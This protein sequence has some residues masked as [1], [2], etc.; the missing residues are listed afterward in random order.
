MLQDAVRCLAVPGERAAELGTG[1]GLVAVS[2]A[3]AYRVVIATDLVKTLVGGVALT[4]ALNRIPDGHCIVGCVADVAC[5]LRPGTH[6]FVAANA[7]WVPSGTAR[8]VV[9]ADGGPT[10]TEL[11]SR[12]VLEGSQLLRAGGVGVFLMAD[13]TFDD[14]RAPL[15]DLCDRSEQAGLFTAVLPT[16]YRPVKEGWERLV[17]DLP[18]AVAARHVAVVVAKPPLDE[19]R[20]AALTQLRSAWAAATLR[21]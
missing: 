12:F 9:Y 5:G 15:R 6:D 4:A 21:R 19:R 20:A 14:G 7:P 17:A 2:L 13:I 8:S 10:G 18:G 11:P 16:P 3:A 1:T